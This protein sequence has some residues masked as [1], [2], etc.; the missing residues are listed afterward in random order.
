MSEET[1]NKAIVNF[2]SQNLKTIS[3]QKVS[4]FC[5]QILSLHRGRLM[6]VSRRLKKNISDNYNTI[7]VDKFSSKA[8]IAYWERLM[9][10]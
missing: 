9:V 8:N 7:S 2:V 5:Q 3:R 4:V 6:L 10:F 1:T